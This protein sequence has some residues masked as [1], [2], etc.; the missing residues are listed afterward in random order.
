MDRCDM[1]RHGMVRCST[2]LA[3]LNP[4]PVRHD[5]PRQL[6]GNVSVETGW[7]V[8]LGEDARV[9]VHRQTQP[10]CFLIGIHHLRHS[11]TG[12]RQFEV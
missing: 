1:V 12:L 2:H 3:L 4:G 7:V 5:P 9:A 6:S 10:G 11:E 8:L